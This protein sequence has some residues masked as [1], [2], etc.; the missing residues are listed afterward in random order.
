MKAKKKV[1][2][3]M[4]LVTIGIVYGDIGTSPMYVMK[5][6][7]EGN[8]GIGKAF[9]PVMLLWFSFLGIS[10]VLH[11]LSFPMVIRA[12]NP[13]RAVQVLISPYNKAGFMIL[14]SVFLATTSAEALYSDMGHVTVVI[15]LLLLLLEIIWYRGTQLEQKYKTRL[16]IA[17]YIP[18]IGKL[19]DDERIP[20]LCHSQVRLH[21]DG[22][23]F[24]G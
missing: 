4:F 7:L 6:I 21:P 5:S 2:A 15:T 20:V 12:F 14:G 23:E 19:R 1:S 17:D 8:G 18:L 9:G 22:T 16:K 24:P 3:A 10:G 13:L 11:I